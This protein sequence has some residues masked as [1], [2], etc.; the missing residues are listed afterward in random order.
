MKNFIK[1]I[2]Q[3]AK[4][5]PKNIVLPEAALDDRILQATETILKE[6][7]AHP[8]LLGVPKEL[9]KKAK[10]LNLTIDWDKVTIMDPKTDVHLEPF[11]NKYVEIRGG[12]INQDQARKELTE[13]INTFGTMI[14]EEDLADGMISGTT[15]STAETIR[16]ALRIIKTKERFHKVSGFFFMIWEDKLLLFSDCAVTIDPNSHDLADIAMD[17]A[18]TAVR[19]GIEPRIA[20]LSF[21]T[22]GSAKH[23]S[24]DK[25]REA[26][27]MIK[28]QKPDLCVEGEMQVDAALIPAIYERKFPKGKS[29]DNFNILI[30]PNLN[31]G[32][33]AYKLVERLA[34]A[35]AIGPI[36]QGLQKPV[37]DLSRGCSA[38]D[39]STL[40]AFTTVEAQGEDKVL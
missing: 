8:V 20:M 27:K 36:L 28:Y 33:I 2:K 29:C 32:N 6:G 40:A 19:F 15:F 25:V 13:D 26:T 17:T 18:E 35:H 39:I 23:P 37:N 1:T 34:G 4:N 30:F 31:A 9:E 22:A 5:D 7:T 14:V 11:V 38:E 24:V 21:S 12:K 16:P 3:K 10:N